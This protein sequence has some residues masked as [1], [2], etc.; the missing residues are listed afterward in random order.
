MKD[1]AG[2]SRIGGRVN[3]ELKVLRVAL[4][5]ILPPYLTFSYQKN[6]VLLKD[7]MGC[8]CI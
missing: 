4:V 8:K 5:G 3:A 2:H 7:F 6:I 1:R